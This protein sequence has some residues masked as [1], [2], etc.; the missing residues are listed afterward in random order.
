MSTARFEDFQVNDQDS[1]I[2]SAP[3]GDFSLDDWRQLRETLRAAEPAFRKVAAEFNLGL[4]SNAR[5]PELRLQRHRG[6]TTDELRLTLQPG[7]LPVPRSESRWA[8]NFVRYP[9]FAWLPVGGSSV[10]TIKVLA[11]GDLHS[12]DLPHD[13]REVIDR[14]APDGK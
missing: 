13:L 8:I 3:D 10:E 5:W 6:W 1:V 11:T 2:P 9:R 12:G 14:L 7:P 4:L